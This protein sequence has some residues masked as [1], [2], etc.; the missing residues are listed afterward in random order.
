MSTAPFTTAD[1]KRMVAALEG[2]GYVVTG[3]QVQRGGGFQLQTIKRDAAA[4][5]GAPR[6]RGDD[7]DAELEAAR[8]RLK[9]RAAAPARRKPGDAPAR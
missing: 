1:V 7:G 6:A 8:D 4:A 9:V 5:G 2:A 3:V